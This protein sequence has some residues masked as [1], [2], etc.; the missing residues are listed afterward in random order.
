MVL[1]EG[2]DDYIKTKERWKIVKQYFQINNIEFMEIQS[3]N[4][5]ILSKLVDLIYVLDYSTIFSAV[6][7]KIDPTP[8]EPINFIKAG[9]WKYYILE[10]FRY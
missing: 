3:I 6:L 1:L 2:T 9:I 7:S 10:I 8:V 5:S 4:G